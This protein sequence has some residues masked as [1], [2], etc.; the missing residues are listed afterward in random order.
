MPDLQIFSP[1]ANFFARLGVKPP[2]SLTAVEFQA[3]SIAIGG[4][5]LL[6]LQNFWE[7]QVAVSLISP[8]H[9]EFMHPSP[10][11]S[12]YHVSVILQIKK[13]LDPESLIS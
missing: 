13:Y 1:S 12:C 11:S 6:R 4:L 7:W 9:V 8:P 10:F 2:L 3:R 5:P